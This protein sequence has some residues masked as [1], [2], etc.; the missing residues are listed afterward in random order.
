MTAIRKQVRSWDQLKGKHDFRIAQRALGANAI[1]CSI[2]LPLLT[3]SR[4]MEKMERS[5]KRLGEICH[6]RQC[7]KTGNDADCLCWTDKPPG[8][9]WKPS[10]R[11][12]S[13]NRYATM[14]TDLYVK[15]GPWLRGIGRTNRFM[16]E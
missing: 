10:L 11:G 5:G 15:Y 16:R 7:I 12:R 4:I 14:E 3:F 9:K 2:S 8:K 6:I 13:I 1:M